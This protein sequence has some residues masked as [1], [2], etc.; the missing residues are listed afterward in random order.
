MGGNKNSMLVD[1]GGGGTIIKNI[2][3]AL[4][5][6]TKPKI[7]AVF[8]LRENG[9]KNNCKLNILPF[10]NIKQKQI[11]YITR[12][13][14]FLE[15]LFNGTHKTTLGYK[16]ND[17]KITPLLNFPNPKINDMIPFINAFDL[18][19]ESFFRINKKNR[20]NRISLSQSL[21]RLLNVPHEKEANFL[22]E[23]YYDDGY[24]SKKFEKV[25]ENSH[26]D[27]V[28]KI[29][30]KK[31]YYK[32]SSNTAYMTRRISWP[33]GCIAKLDHDFIPSIKQLY[34]KNANSQLIDKL[35]AILNENQNILSIYIYGIGDFG[36]ECFTRLITNGTKVKGI[37]D[38][39]AELKE[40]EF[41]NFK[42]KTLQNSDVRDNDT[43]LITSGVFAIEITD[44]IKKNINK[45][46]NIINYYNG[47]VRI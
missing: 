42:V 12:S 1:F 35:I 32:Y 44:F 33:Q 21:I 10:I 26:L 23:L 14:E 3:K 18:G 13:H 46:I 25:I 8:Y 15:V 34:K 7:N 27:I 20:Y 28:K 2:H 19:I 22:G 11:N 39:K 37:I 31:F 9:Y 16:K 45:K 41:K 24:G 29:G 47:L 4:C 17:N 38:S 30:Y 5:N 6:A 36:K 43:I 40:F